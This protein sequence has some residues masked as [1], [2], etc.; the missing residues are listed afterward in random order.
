MDI[1]KI[2]KKDLDLMSYLSTRDL[3][4]VLGDYGKYLELLENVPKAA[5]NARNKANALNAQTMVG[6][7]RDLTN[8]GLNYKAS[9]ADVFSLAQKIG[10]NKAGAK[11]DVKQYSELL[12]IFKLLTKESQNLAKSDTADDALKL[13]QIN[14]NRL[15]VTKEI[16]SLEQRLSS[17][18]GAKDLLSPTLEG[19]V[20]NETEMEQIINQSITK[21]ENIIKSAASRLAQ[22]ALSTFEEEVASRA[23]KT[24]DKIGQ[25][26]DK[27]EMGASAR[28]AKNRPHTEPGD[29]GDGILSSG[30]GGAP[31]GFTSN[32][33]GEID[34][35]NSEFEDGAK[36]VDLYKK[37]LDGL[38]EEF[39]DVKK[40][41]L[42]AEE[43][44][45]K[46]NSLLDEDGLIKGDYEEFIGYATRFNELTELGQVGD[47]EL[48]DDVWDTYFSELESG[49]YDDF[50]DKITRMT[51]A[52]V[53]NFQKLQKEAK[54]TGNALGQVSKVTPAAEAESRLEDTSVNE[55]ELDKLKTKQEELEKQITTINEKLQHLDGEAFQ[56]M[57]KAASDLK[58][59]LDGVLSRIEQLE[60]KNQKPSVEE[61]L[62]KLGLTKETLP[63]MTNQV[64]ALVGAEVGS[65]QIDTIVEYNKKLRDTNAYIKQGNDLIEERAI[66]LKDGR[67]VGQE[68]VMSDKTGKVNIGAGIS[69]TG[70]DS[71]LH[72]HVFDKAIDNLRFSDQDII[73]LVDGTIKKA[74]LMCGDEVLQLDMSKV[75]DFTGLQTSIL[76]TYKAVF[77]KYGASIEGTAIKGIDELPPDVQNQCTNLINSLLYGVVKQYGA[78]LSF[79]KISIEDEDFIRNDHARIQTVTQE[80]FEIVSKFMDAFCSPEP[81]KAITELQRQLGILKDTV[82]SFHEEENFGDTNLPDDNSA[83]ASD[84]PIPGEQ[85]QIAA[86]SAEISALIELIDKKTAAFK[87]E[88]NVVQSVVSEEVASIETLKLRLDDIIANLREIDNLLG[89][90]SNKN[91]NIGIG[92]N[93]TQS[94]VDPSKNIPSGDVLAEEQ[95]KI[96]NLSN[97]IKTLIQLI[98]DKTEAFRAEGD[99]V[100]KVINN[101]VGSIDIL[102]LHLDDLITKLGNINNILSSINGFLNNVSGTSININTNSNG[103]NPKKPKSDEVKAYENLIKT[104]KQYQL[105]SE[106]A[107]RGKAT[108]KELIALE[109]I[110]LA[111][112]QDLAVISQITNKTA[113]IVKLEQEYVEAVNAAAKA[114]DTQN[115]TELGKGFKKYSDFVDSVDRG[116]LSKEE[117]I[118]LDSIKNKISSLEKMLPLDIL[119]DKELQAYVKLLDEVKNDV[120][121]FKPKTVE[122]AQSDVS[123]LSANISSWEEHNSKAAHK[124]RKELDAIVSALGDVKTKHDLDKVKSQ[125]DELRNKVKQTKDEGLSLFDKWKQKMGNLIGYLSSFASFYDIIRYI[126]EGLQIIKD[127][128]TAMTN[129]AKVSDDSQS[130]L[131]AFSKTAF[132]IAE[133]I[134]STGSA[135]ADAATEWARL[136]YS[137]E[138]ASKL[139]EASTIYANVGEIDTATATTDLVSSLKAF[140][141]E[142]ANAMDVVD[143]MNEIGNNYA[144]S[145]AQLGEI[146]EKS[147]STLAVSGDS[148]E[149]V[150][151][152]AA[153]MNEIIQDASTTGTTLKMLGLRIRGASTEIEKMGESTDGMAES[154]SK[155]REKILALTNVDGAGGFDIMKNDK[156]FK[157][158]YDILKGISDVWVEMDQIDQAAL[159]ELIAGKNR[160][161][162]AA[163]LIQN[164]A[165]AEK[166]LVDAYDSEGSALEE[167]E[168]YMESIQ[169]HL[170]VLSNKWQAIWTD[171]ATRDQINTLIDFAGVI[172][173]IVDGVGLI[174]TAL[175]GLMTFA[176][177]KMAIN[178]NSLFGV[179][180]S[181]PSTVKMIT[182]N[183]VK[184]LSGSILSGD[185]I[186]GLVTQY[187]ELQKK[188]ASGM[189]MNDAIKSMGN[190]DDKVISYAKNT[191]VAKQS[192]Q[193][194]SAALKTQSAAAKATSI[195]IGTLKNMLS[196][197]AMMAVLS[198][199][200]WALGKLWDAFDKVIN[201]VKYTAE[202][203]EQL[204][205]S[206]KEFQ[207]T[208]T[209]NVGSISD[210]EGEFAEL[211]KGV[212]AAGKNISLTANEYDR[213]LEVCGQIAN[214]APDLVSYYDEEGNAIV[215]LKGGVD[216]LTE[217]YENQVKAQAKTFIKK[218][219]EEGN[220]VKDIVKDFNN[221]VTNFGTYTWYDE[222]WNAHAGAKYN[223]QEYADSLREL[224]QYNQEELAKVGEH[225]LGSLLKASLT[226]ALNGHDLN[227]FDLTDDN[228]SEYQDALLDSLE[229]AESSINEYVS[230]IE[231]ALKQY[232]YSVDEYWNIDDKSG[233]NAFL[234]NLDVSTILA[235]GL[236]DEE[237]YKKF[238]KNLSTA[239]KDADVSSAVSELMTFNGSDAKFANPEEAAKAANALLQQIANALKE[240]GVEVTIDGLAVSFGADAE[241]KAA[242]EYQAFL[243]RVYNHNA[244]SSSD[245][246]ASAT[247]N[248]VAKWLEDNEL[249]TIEEIDQFEQYLDKTGYDIDKAISN[250]LKDK[251]KGLL[252]NWSENEAAIDKYQEQVGELESMAQKLGSAE[253]S[254]QDWIDSKQFL[255]KNGINTNYINT[256][257][258]LQAAFEGLRNKWKNAAVEALD[259]AGASEEVISAVEGMFDQSTQVS[260]FDNLGELESQVGNIQSAYDTL[261]SSVSEYNKQGFLSMN[262]ID[263]LVGLDDAYLNAL[264]NENGQL[265]FNTETFKELARIKIEEAKVSVYQRAETELLRIANLEASIAAKELSLANGEIT[266]S[267]YKAAEA[268]YKLAIAQGGANS[269]LANNVWDATTRRIAMYDAALVNVENDTYNFGLASSASS[270]NAK[271][272]FAELFDFFERRVTVINQ[273]LDLL[274]T[275]MENV[276]GAGAKNTLLSAQT[277]IVEEEYKNYEDAL[278]M[279]ST[280]AD[281]YFN[282]LPADMQK[283]IKNGSIDLT[284]LMGENGDKVN[285]LLGSYQEWADKAADCKQ[286]L[287][288]LQAT[289]RQ[290][291]LDKFN[292][293]VEQYTD[294]FEIFENSMGVI[295]SMI[296]YYEEA[297][298][299]VGRAF[300]EGQIDQTQE[301]KDILVN[302][303]K[304]LEEQMAKSLDSGRIEEGDAEWLEMNATIADV[305]SQ[306][307][308]CDTSIEEFNNSIL[309]LDTATFD[310]IINRLSSINEE[311]D[312]ITSLLDAELEIG[313]SNKDDHSYTDAATTQMGIYGQ[314]Y[315]NS[316]YQV[317]K[318][319]AEIEKLNQDYAAGLYSQTEYAERLRELILAQYDAANAAQ[320][321]QDAMYE[322]AK[323]RAEEEIESIEESIDA[324]N[325]LID[326]QIETL[327]AEK[328]LHDYRESIKDSNKEI[329]NI[330]RQLAALQYDDSA[331]AI[332]KRKLLEEELAQA[333][334]ER[335]ELEYEHSIEMQTEALNK[336]KE[337]N[338][339]ARQAEIEAIQKYLEDRDQV[340]MDSLNH[341]K[342]NTDVVLNGLKTI[343]E[344]YGIEVTD[345]IVEPWKSGE[346][347]L[348][349]YGVVLT[350]QSSAFI[351][352]LAGV[353][354][355][356]VELQRQADVTAAS[357]A[358]VF[359][360]DAT[361]LLKQLKN[362]YTEAGN[363]ATMAKSVEDSFVNAL[364][365]KYNVENITSALKK[366]QDAANSAA[367]A[368]SAASSFGNG[369]DIGK[370]GTYSVV[371]NYGDRDAWTVAKG[372]SKDEAEKKA[373][374]YQSK[375]SSTSYTPILDSVWNNEKKNSWFT[376]AYAKGG[377]VTKDPSNPLNAIARAVGEDSMIAAKEGEAVL[378]P[379]QTEAM[380]KMAPFLEQMASYIPSFK[381]VQTRVP[382]VA[383]GE[384][385]SIQIGSLVTVNGNVDDNNLSEITSVVKKEMRNMFNKINRDFVYA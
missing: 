181:L 314:Q 89:G 149:Q 316:M 130:K 204:I 12:S 262:T 2:P 325:E 211:S 162:G 227:I 163:A 58:D 336:N 160:A 148:I 56:K 291:E 192:S 30:E 208:A 115:K 362:S 251:A 169:G 256:V 120:A 273:A 294:Q 195:A 238:V 52:H 322:L 104:E 62:T 283:K 355:E 174:N 69:E 286:Q 385:K 369:F 236:N 72:T 222:D 232:A 66:L 157:T 159:L 276:V 257:E 67:Q 83:S 328:D 285:E 17:Q 41:G 77:L 35:I 287:A 57:E 144:V 333:K 274:S 82:Q 187:E 90:I 136:G 140:N 152:M 247:R 241:Q 143:I 42:S 48:P 381:G 258:E 277:D 259:L 166:A 310:R 141:I 51:Q 15:T 289:L 308:E 9:D 243:D 284:A 254:D 107:Y 1:A 359:T 75:S 161:Q 99:T 377:L 323:T 229:E 278:K 313:V 361:G 26:A 170:N 186:S 47:L 183:G 164:F 358:K 202:A 298:E 378:T 244:D 151:A 86:L 301:Q 352:Q 85:Q 95:K 280:A 347:A 142:T 200:M 329:A 53:E 324:Y 13:V 123:A 176:S 363:L 125:W 84:G 50:V 171:T 150:T 221:N 37:A 214:I 173:D 349:S 217:A 353:A 252:F 365:R 193:G 350:T 158:T 91:I 272:D 19:F 98:K 312:S 281:Y 223:L 172:L 6:I 335:E 36:T 379:V 292:N 40:Y 235:N 337:A 100:E 39:N 155:L 127:Y 237:N 198:A 219:D 18:F 116:K 65:D 175:A 49:K 282:Q 188:M 348:A 370:S 81:A 231:Y 371:A 205:S 366:V 368:L 70:A 383:R 364:G 250:Y 87:E 133:N 11:D 46:I 356:E 180:K 260:W 182:T 253:F 270:A 311:L 102:K 265:Q 23:K 330:E 303:L 124:Y 318:Y 268:A 226:K 96:A 110:K 131:D 93:G 71:V 372:L 29:V 165:V 146:L 199:A 331:A 101:E 220:K 233:I 184:G 207:D 327:E 255:E 320:D 249:N 31:S 92:S 319:D 305:N 134:G 351:S 374:E 27:V 20:S 114:R 97:E 80:D 213:Y 103:Q 74:F 338:E 189:S 279:Y 354:A 122:V 230:N 275:N 293:I 79:D 380:L 4:K 269:V 240:Q 43:T 218:G 34:D 177:T 8:H 44:L 33:P 224:I 239:M 194:F 246:N 10:A 64:E 197:L 201:R 190:L 264:V 340:I 334:E 117:N 16:L 384:S 266:E 68:Y 24:S 341:V 242:D 346:G 106:K 109:E 212:S 228:F 225:E 60:T 261:L 296:G 128:D 343:T 76:D 138:E 25:Q 321:A 185:E 156:E 45:A 118:E 121:D 137:I 21:Y 145:S 32:V 248:R 206:L 108:S 7:K 132:D 382:D 267:A 345:D 154:S 196:S 306:I 373:A 63:G 245:P 299:L 3:Q 14:K 288:E 344:Q 304:D 332:A 88:G 38:E 112:S 147:S 73:E 295:D 271:A 216:S 119:N 367:S 309:A 55:T 290:I 263:Q 22:G 78:S 209:K 59:E 297:G 135:V 302:E 126:R 357:V 215:R 360:A 210:L 113:E 129:L 105:L 339:E 54:E 61:E 326:A 191:N 307:I 5:E 28:R 111:R 178:G 375:S 300:Y 179:L 317:Q 153:A 315:E 342:E 376:T 168:K 139:A 234:E 94:N 203:A 167:N